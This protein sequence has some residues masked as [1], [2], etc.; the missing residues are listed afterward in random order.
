MKSGSLLNYLYH[1][2][3]LLHLSVTIPD[4]A[5]RINLPF[6]Y[7]TT[8]MALAH[9]RELQT[10]YVCFSFGFAKQELPQPSAIQLLVSLLESMHTS[11]VFFKKSQLIKAWHRSHC[12]TTTGTIS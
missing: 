4:L 7:T 3:Y 8:I 5:P 10:E 6:R 11:G 1:V 12:G 9:F 2:I